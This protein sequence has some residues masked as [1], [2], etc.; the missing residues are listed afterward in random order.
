MT[1]SDVRL[2]AA[3][4][5]LVT[6]LSLSLVLLS[7]VLMQNIL[8]YGVHGSFGQQHKCGETAT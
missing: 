4:E 3:Q 2:S 1:Q 6:L 7:A 8:F 5:F